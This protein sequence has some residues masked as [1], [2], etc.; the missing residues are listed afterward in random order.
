MPPD[1]IVAPMLAAVSVHGLPGA[2]ASIVVALMKS[3]LLAAVTTLNVN[4]PGV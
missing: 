4:A 3:S 1:C 2:T